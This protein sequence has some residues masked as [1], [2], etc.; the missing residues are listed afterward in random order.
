MRFVAERDRG[1]E[2]QMVIGC[3]RDSARRVRVKQSRAVP[4]I[5]GRPATRPAPA[6]QLLIIEEYYFII[7]LKP[8]TN[9]VYYHFSASD[10]EIELSTG[11]NL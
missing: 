11:K 2:R 4:A 1:R 7:K 8:N 10:R 9:Y 5:R 3:P 6:L